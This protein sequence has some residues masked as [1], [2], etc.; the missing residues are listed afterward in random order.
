MT[1]SPSSLRLLAFAIP[2]A[3]VPLVFA[4]TT[5]SW[6]DD[7]FRDCMG[8]AADI[9]LGDRAELYADYYDVSLDDLQNYRRGVRDAW[10][11][12]GETQRKTFLKQIDRDQATLLKNRQQTLKDRL[13]SL[14]ETRTDTE[15]ACKTRQ[16][17]AKKFTA[18]ICTSTS[19]CSSGKVCS[20]EQGIC[21]ASCPYGS[22]YCP[23]ACAGTC[24]KP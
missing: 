3:L 11:I 4:A 18:S 19:Q 6:I 20:T 2:F 24:V 23:N 21:N 5:P 14:T 8:R 16:S 10:H 1:R 12:V 9:E 15:A 13:K 17:D 7:E 22:F